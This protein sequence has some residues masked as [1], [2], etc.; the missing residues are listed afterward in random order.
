MRWLNKNMR[1][2]NLKTNTNPSSGFLG[3]EK[4]DYSSRPNEFVN[5]EYGKCYFRIVICGNKSYTRRIP[6]RLKEFI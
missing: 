1:V 3:M 2:L 6:F 5:P 4:L